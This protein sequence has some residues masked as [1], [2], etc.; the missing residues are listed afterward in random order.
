MMDVVN[1][2][3]VVLR[4][5]WTDQHRVRSAAILEKMIPLRPCLDQ[6]AV[7]IDNGDAVLE[8]GRQACGRQPKGARET[9][10]IARQ[11]VRQLQLAAVSDKDSVGRLSENPA[12]RSP[13]VSFVWQWVGPA[14]NRFV[15]TG[16]VVSAFL[17]AE[18]GRAKQ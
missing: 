3:D 9:I 7:G 10:E 15:R 14:L 8:H 1:H 11:F 16:A 5:I 17:L 12:G 13:N 4:I 2:P 6:L 18:S